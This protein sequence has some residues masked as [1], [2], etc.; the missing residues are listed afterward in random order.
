MINDMPNNTSGV[1][2]SLFA[3]D[4]AIFA[5]GRRTTTL[6][7]RIQES[8]SAI[9]KWCD[10]SGFRISTSKTT[11]V[12][13]THSRQRGQDID[14]TD[15]AK[16]LGVVFDRRLSWKPHIDYTITK[17]RRM[18][19]LCAVSGQKWGASKK[20]LLMIYRALIRPVPEYGH[21]VIVKCQ[22][23]RQTTSADLPK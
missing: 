20:S 14:I 12:L 8:L 22:Q 11:A 4:S 16:F 7:K 3:D 13:F 19:L 18:G 17:C 15:S 1:D 9:Q 6:E 10:R 23:H 2:L 5:A 21:R